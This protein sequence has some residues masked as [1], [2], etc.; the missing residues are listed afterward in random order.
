MPKDSH[1]RGVAGPKGQQGR[2]GKAGPVGL[3]GKTGATGR[4][5]ARGGQGATGAIGASLPAARITGADRVEL[6]SVVQMQM[7]NVH[8]EL[9]T[10]MIRMAR[11]ETAMAGIEDKLRALVAEVSTLV[12]AGRTRLISDAGLRRKALHRGSVAKRPS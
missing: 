1:P 12:Q 11:L 10:Q 8:R 9:D 4:R 7:D 3:P 2:A 5:G 6:L